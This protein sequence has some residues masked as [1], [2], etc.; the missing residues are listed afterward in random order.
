MNKYTW[1]VSVWCNL[2][3]VMGV[4][5]AF[6]NG[7]IR[8]WWSCCSYL[9]SYRLFCEDLEIW[10]NTVHRLWYLITYQTEVEVVNSV[11]AVKFIVMVTAKLVVLSEQVHP[12]SWAPFCF[13]L[14]TCH[15]FVFVCLFFNFEVT[16]RVN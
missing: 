11:L 12:V 13:W 10:V 14:E 9:I 5:R 8:Q 2:C 4:V 1:V 3:I 6:L 15:L 16:D 7:Y